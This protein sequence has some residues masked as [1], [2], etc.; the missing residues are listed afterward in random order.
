MLGVVEVHEVDTLDLAQP[1]NHAEDV[2]PLAP[3]PQVGALLHGVEPGAESKRA[4][5]VAKGGVGFF[6]RFR[7]RERRR[8][9]TSVLGDEI[10]RFVTRGKRRHSA[11]DAH[12]VR[13]RRRGQRQTPGILHDVDALRD[14]DGERR[15]ERVAR[16]GAVH[17]LTD[18][19]DLT[20]RHRQRVVPRE[21]AGRADDH[22]AAR[23]EGDQHALGALGDELEA[24]GDRLV[25]RRRRHAGEPRQLG[26]VRA[27]VIRRLEERGGYRGVHT[28]GVHDDGNPRGLR[29]RR[30]REVDPVGD[31]PLQQHH[32]G[33]PRCSDHRRHELVVVLGP[34]GVGAAD[35]HG[36][37]LAAG[38]EHDEAR[39]RGKVRVASAQ[40]D[41]DAVRHELL[42]EHRRV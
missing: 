22:R 25:V 12:R 9:A 30:G 1:A 39:P 21:H 5:V 40:G 10:L 29:S 28:P 23:A 36:R 6:A 13:P 14:G 26:L 31:L 42:L 4:L 11:R 2:E 17:D 7:R 38:R 20:A 35:D 8:G 34:R 16:R 37:R 18:F 27:E 41:I 32:R 19:T 33:A 24:R 15:P 3:T